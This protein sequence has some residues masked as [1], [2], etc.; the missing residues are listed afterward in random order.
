MLG[1]VDRAQEN[2]SVINGSHCTRSH[3]FQATH[4]AF[5]CFYQKRRAFVYECVSVYDREKGR[6]LTEAG[7]P[8]G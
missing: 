7:S 3:L 5:L 2:I 8:D 6:E 4:V 1:S